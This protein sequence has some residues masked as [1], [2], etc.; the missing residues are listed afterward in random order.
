[1]NLEIEEGIHLIEKAMD[2]EKEDRFFQR[3]IPYQS[4]MAYDEFKRVLGDKA[5]T[6]YDTRTTEEILLQAKDILNLLN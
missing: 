3:W 2:E 4:E 6:K 1:M 5:R